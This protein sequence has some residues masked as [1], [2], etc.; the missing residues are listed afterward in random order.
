MDNECAP[1]AIVIVFHRVE[2]KA[3]EPHNGRGSVLAASISR[4]AL[5]LLK[6]SIPA[7]AAALATLVA[8]SAWHGLDD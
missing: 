2:P 4:Q 8:T 6:I 7:A 1:R 5:V 3:S